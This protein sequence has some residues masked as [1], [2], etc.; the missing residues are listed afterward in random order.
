MSNY[1]LADLSQ[2]VAR[3]MRFGNVTDVQTRPP[4]CRVTFGT[5]PITGEV[6][7]TGWLRLAGSADNN[8]SVWSLPATGASVLVLSPGG[9]VNG[10]LVFPA[11]FTDDRTPPSDKTGEYVISFGNG[12][13]VAYSMDS[14]V[15]DVSLPEGGRVRIKANVDID[16][17]LTATEVNDKTGS[18]QAMR[19]VHNEHTHNEHGDG[20]G[21][22]DPPNQKMQSTADPEQSDEPDKPGS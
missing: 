12:A 8:L 18:M 11:G 4:R 9:E 15:M 7:E 14:N 19:E 10:G 21:I 16:G 22:T 6:H 2:R 13:A 1:A 17:T 3:M 5:D 20:G